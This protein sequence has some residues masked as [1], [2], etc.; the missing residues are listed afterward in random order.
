M[1]YW[2]GIGSRMGRDGTHGIYVSYVSHSEGAMAE[3][4]PIRDSKY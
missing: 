2:G 4:K 1:N 3:N